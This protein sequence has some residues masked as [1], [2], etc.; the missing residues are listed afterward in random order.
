M[1]R[2]HDVHVIEWETSSRVHVVRGATCKKKQA[3]TRPDFL[4]PEIWLDTSKAAKKREKQELALEKRK[5]DNDRKLRG[6]LFI[7][8]EDEEYKENAR[9]KLEVL[10]EAAMPCEMETRKRARKPQENAAS[11]STD[12]H[13][14]TKYA[15]IVE[16]H[17]STR[18]RLESTLPRNSQDHIAE[19]GLIQ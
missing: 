3:T 13:K 19:K 17:E 4:W 10:M 5:F 11:A 6:I 2:T 18:K 16:A 1:N 7:D 12:S 8:P 9:K 14:K 15:F